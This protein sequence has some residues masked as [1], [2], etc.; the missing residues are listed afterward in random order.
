MIM[1]PAS[2]R[3]IDEPARRLGLAFVRVAIAFSDFGGIGLE[4]YTTVVRLHFKPEVDGLRV[5]V[6]E[7]KT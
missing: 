2:Q 1:M 6:R 7:H 3:L 5:R 4:L